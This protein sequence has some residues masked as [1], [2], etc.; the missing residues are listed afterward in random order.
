MKILLATD[1]SFYSLQ[2]A[3]FLGSRLNP[4]RV[5]GLRVVAVAAGDPGNGT[6]DAGG[7][8]HAVPLAVARRW[9]DRTLEA[10]QGSGVPLDGKVLQGDPARTLVDLAGSGSFDLVVA[11]VKGQ[12]AAPFFELGRVATALKQKVNTPV[13]LVRPPGADPSRGWM[14]DDRVSPLRVLLPT[15]GEGR[16]VEAACRL[17]G[18]FRLA[19]GSVEIAALLGGSVGLSGERPPPRWTGRNRQERRT[20][21]RSWLA[22]T[23]PALDPWEVV[24]SSLLEGRPVREIE[25]RVRETGSDLLVLNLT[26]AG[27]RGTGAT[28][29]AEEL[30]WFAPC[31][32]LL[33]RDAVVGTAPDLGM[34]L[35]QGRMAGSGERVPDELHLGGSA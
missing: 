20:R 8:S 2:A 25:R 22:Q 16:E 3:A 27:S 19:R 32:V 31:S 23:L 30:A 1:G 13:L 34:L 12:G 33:L 29:V 9:V 11:G 10:L 24:S 15:A 18:A 7:L 6:G 17:L 5:S 28:R 14:D 4:E 21:A 35:D 26:E